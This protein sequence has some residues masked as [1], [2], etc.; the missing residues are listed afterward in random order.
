L[1]GGTERRRAAAVMV[2]LTLIWGYA[3]VVAKVGLAYSGPFDFAALRVLVGVLTLGLWLVATGRLARPIL[4]A[5]AA[6]IGLVQTAAF[7][8]L[9]TWALVDSGPGKTSILVF[10][11]PFW[12]LL[13]ARPGLGERL[14]GIQWWAV[15][16]AFAGLLLVLEPWRLQIT[17]LSKLLAVLASICW[18]AGVILAKRLQRR[19]EV[20]L[21]S[22]T[23]WQMLIGLV[24]MALVAWAVPARSVDW[25]VPFVL[26]L[27][28]SGVVA[29]GFG[30]LMWLYVLHRL[31]AGTTSLASLA[32]P[33]VAALSS[34]I[35]LGER[36]RPAEL[37]GML[38]ISIALALVSWD[39]GRRKRIPDAA[40]GQE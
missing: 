38:V 8:I 25:T 21:L 13:F 26:A 3:W 10:T 4:L 6:I 23:F 24:P 37:G 27:L 2:V 14:Q 32:I 20:D 12:V 22:F 5:D 33:V 18:A 15:G 19:E 35:Q 17:L 31:P 9:N 34:A 40:M 39:A 29:T 30:W 36:L 1:N 11:M 28:F 7:L 16:L